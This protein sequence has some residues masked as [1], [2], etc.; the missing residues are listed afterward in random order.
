[1]ASSK[2]LLSNLRTEFGTPAV[3]DWV[4]SRQADME[5]GAEARIRPRE[6][7]DRQSL[8]MR[9]MDLTNQW[10]DN[11]DSDDAGAG[12]RPKALPVMSILG[13]LN[14]TRLYDI[15]A[16][17]ELAFEPH[18]VPSASH[19]PNSRPSPILQAT[20]RSDPPARC[21]QYHSDRV[22]RS[23]ALLLK[24]SD[25]GNDGWTEENMAELEGELGLAL[26]EQ[27]VESSSVGTP[28]SPSPRSVEAPQNEIRGRGRSE[29]TGSRPEELQ[30]ASRYGTAQ[31]IKEWKRRKTEV[32]EAGGVAMQEQQ[33]LAAQREELG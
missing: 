12:I 18:G 16:T 28:S 7:L 33:E 15:F 20:G 5:D 32:V 31:R 3:G 24:L 22:S 13:E 29:T 19:K 27:K 10:L 2:F 23:C 6:E 30:D 8:H 26:G 21:R 14:R 4:T 1:M 11:D 17:S 25:S 9:M